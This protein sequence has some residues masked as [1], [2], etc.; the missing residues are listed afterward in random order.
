MKLLYI[1]AKQKN[2]DIE[3]NALE[4]KKLPKKLFLAYSIQYQDLANN[5]AKQLEKNKIQIKQKQQDKQLTITTFP[6]SQSD[7][8]LS[9]NSPQQP[10]KPNNL[11]C[12]QSYK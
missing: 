4:L 2:L 11:S 3:I 5:I 1:P 8:K 6:K 7:I 10:S 12:H 9:T